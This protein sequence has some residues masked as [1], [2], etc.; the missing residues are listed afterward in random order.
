MNLVDHLKRLGT[1][2]EA[3]ARIGVAQTTVGC[4]L[5]G[6]TL[7]T[8]LAIP[9]LAHALDMPVDDLRSLIAAERAARAAAKAPAEQV[10][11]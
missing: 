8:N 7:P 11:A 2:M 3:A 10:V 4:W 1:Q 9:T 6:E 5:R